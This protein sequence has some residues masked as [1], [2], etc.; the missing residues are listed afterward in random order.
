MLDPKENEDWLDS[1][2]RRRIALMKMQG[3][4]NRSEK[5]TVIWLAIAVGLGVFAM[6]GSM[7][8]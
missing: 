2:H 7:M 6:F 8:F 4:I 1:Q 5:R 3:D